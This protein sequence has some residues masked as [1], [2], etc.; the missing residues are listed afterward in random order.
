MSFTRRQIL[1]AAA[2]LAVLVPGQAPRADDFIELRARNAELGLL[3]GGAGKT[4]AWILGKGPAPAVIRAK[5]GQELKLRIFNELDNEIWLH[6]FGLRGPSELMTINVPPGD[7]GVDCV[8]TPPD[9]GT[10]WI[11]PVSDVSRHRDM[12]LYAMLVV[13]EKEALDPAIP[14]LPLIIDDWRIA[15]DGT[16]EGGFG[17]IETMVGEGRLGNWMTINSQFRPR[18]PIAAGRFTRLRILNAANVRSMGL[19][20]KGSD[21]LLIA[22]DG[23]PVKPRL[24]GTKA[25]TLAPGQRAD[26]LVSAEEGDITIALDLF[27]DVVEI[28][29]LTRD[30]EAAPAAI[31]DNFAL[32]PNPVTRP[33]A[34]PEP[35]LVKIALEGGVKGGLK[36]AVFR[37]QTM[38]LR[39]LLENGK[40][41]AL[42]GVAGPGIEPLFA[43]QLGESL[44][45]EIENRTAFS[46]ALHLHGHVWQLPAEEGSEPPVSDTAVVPAGQT[47]LLGFVADNPGTWAF[48]S[49]VAER[50]DGGLI[51]AFQV[52]KPDQ[53]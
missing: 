50:S 18:L 38:E 19:Q 2:S 48:Q 34:K 31:D 28:G 5:Q 22:F 12:G 43:A 35:R 6:F 51:G 3:E 52:V 33:P 25:L 37:G 9:A 46:Q 40:G 13:E 20:F 1:A 42:N 17:D 53:L 27:E 10:F 36:S 21:P 24:L 4:G 49:L 23:Q 30:G 39:T 29:Y 41:W 26:L 8:F 45:L 14:D 15:Q 44:A 7:K 47:K 11:G 16:M 32:P